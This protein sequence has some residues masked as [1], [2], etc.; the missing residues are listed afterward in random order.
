MSE[1]VIG[2]A[3]AATTA[4]VPGTSATGDS[5]A[6]MFESLTAPASGTERVALDDTPGFDDF[7]E[8][9]DVIGLIDDSGELPVHSSTSANS[10][11]FAYRVNAGNNG[12]QRSVLSAGKIDGARSQIFST[13]EGRIV[14]NL[15]T[16]IGANGVHADAPDRADPD[17]LN[18]TTRYYAET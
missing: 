9:G 7:P 4:M 10:S 2:F 6:G 18:T 14:S 12:V 17:S 8:N 13:A 16:S 5:A 3:G 1:N 11:T 15:L